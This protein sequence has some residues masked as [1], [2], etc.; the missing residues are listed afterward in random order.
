[1]RFVIIPSSRY[2]L[3]QVKTRQTGLVGYI[4]LRIETRNLYH[5]WTTSIERT[6]GR[7]KFRWH[8]NIKIGTKIS[9]I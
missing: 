2:S 9:N 6:A 3:R 4:K 5:L 7:H 8:D 1:V